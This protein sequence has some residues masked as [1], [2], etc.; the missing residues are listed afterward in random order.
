LKIQYY[1]TVKKHETFVFGII[2]LLTERVIS[3]QTPKNAVL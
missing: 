3:Y 2:E 1:L